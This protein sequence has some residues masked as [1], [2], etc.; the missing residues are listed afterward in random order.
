[1][2]AQSNWAHKRL[3]KLAAWLERILDHL[4]I[5]ATL[6]AQ[7]VVALMISRLKQPVLALSPNFRLGIPDQAHASNYTNTHL[8]R[9]D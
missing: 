1:M 2:K 3:L 9:G 6:L 4:L 8:I 5:N 7:M